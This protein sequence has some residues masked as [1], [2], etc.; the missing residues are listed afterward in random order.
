MTAL[1]L[2]L[3]DDPLIAMD[4]AMVCEENGYAVLG[5]AHSVKE[6]LDLLTGARPDAAVLDVNLG[7][8]TSLPVAERLDAEGVPLMVVS[9][10]AER[11]MPQ[12]LQG[13]RRLAKPYRAQDLAAGIEALLNE[14]TARQNT[15]NL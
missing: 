4:C 7:T 11:S 12:G 3:D 2:I 5:P 6:A 9:G 14:E 10:Y 8:E 13:R 1:I 15:A